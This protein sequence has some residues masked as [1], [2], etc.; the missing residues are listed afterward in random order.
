M[1]IK[2][3]D[4]CKDKNKEAHVKSFFIDRKMDASGSMSD[5]YETMDICNDCKLDIYKS[6][7]YVFEKEFN[8]EI[9][10]CLLEEAKK[11]RHRLGNDR[12]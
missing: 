11:L 7:L 12:K 1:D 5:E 4:V 10:K 3:C 6:V 9:D 2:V 8:I